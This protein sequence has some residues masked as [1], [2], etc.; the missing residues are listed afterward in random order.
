MPLAKNGVIDLSNWDF[1]Q[2]GL[3]KL[4][5][6]WNFYW[7][8]FLYEK[9]F[10]SEN[11]HL[12]T[13][14]I[15]VPGIWRYQDFNLQDVGWHGY[16]T[17]RLKVL[18][19]PGRKELV[20]ELQD[21][22]SAYEMDINGEVVATCGQIGKTR[23]SSKPEFVVKRPVIFS[24]S[25]ELYV[26]I[27]LSE[28]HRD[29]GGVF[30]PISLGRNEQIFL[31][32]RKLTIKDW[33]LIGI[34]LFASV[35]HFAL[36]LL[37]PKEVVNLYFTLFCVNFILRLFTRGEKVF[38]ELTG[39]DMWWLVSK[40]EFV[41]LYMIPILYILYFDRLFSIPTLVKRLVQGF[42]GVFVCIV[43][44]TPSYVYIHTL[45]IFQI[46][47]VLLLAYGVYVT[48][49]AYQKQANYFIVFLFG[50]IILL[51]GGVNDVLNLKYI[52]YTRE[53]F[54]YSCIIFIFSQAC[55]LAN[56]SVKAFNKEEQL[57]QHL[58][59]KVAERT[60][61]LSKANVVKGKLLSIVSHDLRGPLT[62]LHGLLGLIQDNQLDK[63]EEKKLFKGI[64]ES[65]HSSMNLLDNILLWAS[66]QLKS[67]SVQANIEPLKLTNL[68]DDSIK[69]FIHQANQKN[70][71][72][73]S[74]VPAEC[75]VMADKNMLK[76]VLR[77]LISNAIKFTLDHGS[78][79]IS[80]GSEK[81]QTVII[82]TDTGIGLSEELEDNIFRSEV[83]NS[84][85]GTSNEKG[86]G[87]GLILCEDLITQ[88]NG[89]I[90]ASSTPEQTGS[91]FSFSLPLP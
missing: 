56:K 80:C 87:V 22:R 37:R 54:D 40:I 1:D 67:N 7:K 18:L 45:L 74:E 72:I 70:I 62:S 78:I 12:K 29:S 64:A 66:S 60:E 23:D 11:T 42:F 16:A 81:D 25:S 63:K 14:N 2:Q 28:F 17:M 41:S 38:Y 61:Q 55:G 76:S 24:D 71:V 6:E 51:I 53:V 27:R 59:C 10:S 8:Q 5:G 57:S 48:F 19:P 88:M 82:I 52:I 33:L 13:E 58:D 30:M 77:N 89:R 85:L 47:G 21:I 91:I 83:V 3:V 43:A 49:M 15:I 90:W 31:K 9:D 34:L 4:D 65:L 50:F 68:V 32:G 79:T 86:M 35:Y 20:M 36:Y 75:K 84:R 69:P 44:L 26:T 73:R 46:S 39:M